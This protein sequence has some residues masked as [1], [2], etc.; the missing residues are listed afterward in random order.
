MKEPDAEL[1]Q[2]IGGHEIPRT[3]SETGEQQLQLLEVV[4]AVENMKKAVALYED[5]FDFKFDIEW[6][7]P[8]EHMNV[9]A[10]KLGD[11]LLQIVESTSPE[12]VVARFIQSHGE[13][14]NHIAFKVDDL[15]KMV[16]KLRRKGVKLVP[17]EPVATQVS[18]YIF[19]HPKSAHGVLIELIQHHGQA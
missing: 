17:E 5:L 15:Q 4:I 11:T 7:M 8:G 13:G 18:S 12:G 3:V 16:A 6:A 19:V 2:R 14:L 9:K 10:T 1:L